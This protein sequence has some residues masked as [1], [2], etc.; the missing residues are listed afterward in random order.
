[1]LP[2]EVVVRREA[3]G[4]YLKRNPHFAKGQLFPQL[5][6]EL[7]LKTK[8]R[9]WKGKP[10]VC[11]DPLMVYEEGGCADQAVQSGQA[12]PGPGAV[13]GAGRRRRCSHHDE[14]WKLFP[15]MRRIARQAFLVLEK[16]W[17]L[18][19]GTLVDFKVE[20]G[21]DAKGQPAA[22]R[23]DRQRLLAGD[24][25]RRLYRQAGLPRRRRARRLWRRSTGRSPR[26]PAASGCRASAS[27]CGAAPTRTRPRRSRAALGDLKDLMTVVTCSMHKEPVAA[28]GTLHRMIAGGAGLAW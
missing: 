27:S 3:H 20:F 12:D 5:I 11:D 14:E 19:G 21:F 17:Q 8:D 4:S 22:R 25:E 15:E 1:M 28:A 10:L 9:N 23:R 2:Y 18:E 24:R 6:V 7:F 13:P 16:A 26:S